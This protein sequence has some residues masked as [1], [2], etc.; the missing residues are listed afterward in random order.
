MKKTY[1]DVFVGGIFFVLLFLTRYNNVYAESTSAIPIE[2]GESYNI[3]TDIS[4]FSQITSYNIDNP[5]IISMDSDGYIRGLQPGETVITITYLDDSNNLCTYISEIEVYLS[6]GIYRIKNSNTGKYLSLND[7]KIKKDLSLKLVNSADPVVESEQYLTQLWRINSYESTTDFIVQPYSDHNAVLIYDKY[8]ETVRIDKLYE[9]KEYVFSENSIWKLISS[10][11]ETSHEKEDT[12]VSL[13][14]FYLFGEGTL[15]YTWEFEQVS[16]TPN[17]V[18]LID[19]Y[20]ENAPTVQS[21]FISQGS[22]KTLN[23]LKIR[24]LAYSSEVN[25]ENVIWSSSN[26]S[27]ATV[28]ATSGKVSGIRE[29]TVTITA[30]NSN[31][32][33][34]Y[35]LTI[36]PY[37]DGVYDITNVLGNRK[38]SPYYF[39]YSGL[40]GHYIKNDTNTNQ[41]TFWYLQSMIDGTY[42]ISV[43][44]NSNAQGKCWV[45]KDSDIGCLNLINYNEN[46]NEKPTWTLQAHELGTTIS[47][48]GDTNLSW[49][50]LDSGFEIVDLTLPDYEDYDS[51]WRIGEVVVE[52]TPTIY[53]HPY[54]DAYFLANHGND[55]ESAYAAM[56]DY[57]NY[58]KSIFDRELGTNIVI[59]EP[60]E[61]FLSDSEL[62]KLNQVGVEN[63][64]GVDDEYIY[65]NNFMNMVQEIANGDES[66]LYTNKYILFPAYPFVTATGEYYIPNSCN[67]LDCS[68]IYK[69]YDTQDYKYSTLHELSHT[70]GVDDHYHNNSGENGE[71]TVGDSCS[72]CG[73]YM[74]KRHE[75]CVINS[76]VYDESEPFCNDCLIELK[77]NLYFKCFPSSEE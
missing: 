62:Q 2:I 46:K 69:G 22:I 6:P 61:F 32:S 29:G 37:K 14:E 74:Y 58:A 16:V 76:N 3:V 7:I 72:E 63:K 36:M 66:Y 10:K 28:D 15:E 20:Y 30:K 4:N 48:K 51:M 53:I 41:R 56:Y 40:I 9:F 34:S 11:I 70:I 47:Y 26:T 35:T 25:E 68:F 43:A 44:N 52:D 13:N 64:G 59:K 77:A 73:A 39:S 55:K 67:K 18:R 54:Y 17:G 38:I 21:R 65:E 75:Y 49:R 24:V 5:S 33:D 1:M 31:H 57:L 27:I 23:D 8:R 45:A 42:K 60:V 71:C 19:E 12:R 50:L